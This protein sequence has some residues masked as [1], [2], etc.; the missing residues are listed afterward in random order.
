MKCIHV[1]I[2]NELWTLNWIFR[3][4]T[5]D[6]VSGGAN[7]IAT[8]TLDY[9]PVDQQI[10]FE[11][12]DALEEVQITINEDTLVEGDEDFVVTLTSS[13]AT[14]TVPSVTITIVDDDCE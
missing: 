9:Q 5:S 10:T 1:Y 14:V 13:D 2:F 4:S 6:G 11:V 3:V 8:A 12:G 7:G